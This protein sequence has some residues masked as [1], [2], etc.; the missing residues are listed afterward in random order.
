M[1][2]LYQQLSVWLSSH[3]P[4]FPPLTLSTPLWLFAVIYDFYVMTPLQKKLALLPW[5]LTLFAS[6]FSAEQQ[7]SRPALGLDV[8][9]WHF[10]P[11]D[12]DPQ[13]LCSTCSWEASRA[14]LF[15]L[16]SRFTLASH[17][18]HARTQADTFLSLLNI[19]QAHTLKLTRAHPPR[20]RGQYCKYQGFSKCLCVWW[21][22][23]VLERVVVKQW[24]GNC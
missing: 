3:G 23:R 21:G 22:C 19:M 14:M 2:P 5:C 12:L 4:V 11:T 17:N 24:Q 13:P 1:T 20:K 9:L 18:T 6:H 15:F 10:A 7:R 8:D 16:I